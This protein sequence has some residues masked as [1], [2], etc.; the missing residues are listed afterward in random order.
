MIF[1]PKVFWIMQRP[2]WPQGLYHPSHEHDACGMGFVV[3]L[4]GEKSHDIVRKGIEI[5]INLIENAFAKRVRDAISVSGSCCARTF[6]I[7]GS[8]PGSR[9]AST[10]IVALKTP[11]TA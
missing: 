5:L 2:P 9:T 6:S 3:N 11:S 7:S 10:T 8:R 4:S 1:A